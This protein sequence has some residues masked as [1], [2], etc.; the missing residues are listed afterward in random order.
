VFGVV[1]AQKEDFFLHKRKPQNN[2]YGFVY[3]PHMKKEEK[4]QETKGK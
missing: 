2:I 3:V 4:Q 1:N